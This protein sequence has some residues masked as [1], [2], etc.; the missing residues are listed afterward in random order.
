MSNLYVTQMTVLGVDA[1]SNMHALTLCM[2]SY[3]SHLDWSNL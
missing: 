1:R 2:Q 3:M